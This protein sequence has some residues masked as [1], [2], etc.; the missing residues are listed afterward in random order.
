MADINE[1]PSRLPDE[2]DRTIC[3]CI[4]MMTTVLERLQTMKCSGFLGK[5]NTVLT[6]NSLPKGLNV[7]R[8]SVVLR[9]QILTV[10]SEEAL[11]IL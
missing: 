1:P 9:D 11:R 7:D 4:F 8:Q 2:N 5:I 10:P 6:A 3:P